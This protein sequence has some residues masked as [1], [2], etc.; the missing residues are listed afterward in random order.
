MIPAAEGLRM[1]VNW[2]GT[3]PN[4]FLVWLDPHGARR[5]PVC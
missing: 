5:F 4:A 3:G 1:K 2:E